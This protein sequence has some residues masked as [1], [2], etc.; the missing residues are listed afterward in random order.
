MLLQLSAS[1]SCHC[2]KQ[3]HRYQAGLLQQPPSRLQQATHRQVATGTETC[4]ARVILRDNRRG[5]VTPMLRDHLHW[6]R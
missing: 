2:V 4:A 3:S 6:L 5:H 1:Q